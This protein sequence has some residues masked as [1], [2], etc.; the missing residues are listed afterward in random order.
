MEKGEY[1]DVLKWFEGLPPALRDGKAYALAARPASARR[2]PGRRKALRR[3]GHGRR[4]GPPP[5]GRQMHDLA[6][7][8]AT[9]K[10]Y[11]DVPQPHYF[12]QTDLLASPFVRAGDLP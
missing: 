7:A 11:V 5:T 10:I 8:N 9:A 4:H 2:L 6:K 12:D 1:E 3:G